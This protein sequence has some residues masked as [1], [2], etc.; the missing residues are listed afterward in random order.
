[1]RKKLHTHRLSTGIVLF[2][3][4][5]VIA[6]N[7]TELPFKSSLGIRAGETSGLSG[8]YFMKYGNAFETIIGFWPYSLGFTQ[9][10]EK[11]LPTGANNMIWYMGVGTHVSFGLLKYRIYYHPEKMD[12]LSRASAIAAGADLVLGTEYHFKN[13]PLAIST[14]LKPFTEINQSGVLYFSIDPAINLKY[15]LKSH[16]E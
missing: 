3:W 16:Y 12:N 1:M 7:Q 5:H 10:Y 6:Q 13:L 14:E 2:G 15:T 8:K 4:L 9:L 11:H